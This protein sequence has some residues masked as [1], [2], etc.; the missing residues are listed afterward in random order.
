MMSVVVVMLPWSSSQ[1]TEAQALKQPS[2]VIEYQRIASYLAKRGGCCDNGCVICASRGF[3]LPGRRL[4]RC[5]SPKKHSRLPLLRQQC[6]HRSSCPLPL[7]HNVSNTFGSPVSD[8]G[9]IAGH[10]TACKI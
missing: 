7:L 1:V 6:L 5:V 4:K 2:R 3:G 10:S 8:D 9:W